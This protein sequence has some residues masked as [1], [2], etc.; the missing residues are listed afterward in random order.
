MLS[1]YATELFYSLYRRQNVMA[2]AELGVAY[3]PARPCSGAGY[4]NLDPQPYWVPKSATEPT[5]VCVECLV[6]EQNKPTL[7]KVTE[8]SSVP[9]R[10]PPACAK[11]ATYPDPPPVIL[12]PEFIA[13]QAAYQLRYE[14]TE[15]YSWVGSGP[16]W[17]R[18]L[19]W[20]Q[21]RNWSSRP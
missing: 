8:P 4:A 3:L 15:Y 14:N 5:R 2:G 17:S 9:Y 7:F 20:Y 11:R 1:S 16:K 21:D 12:L 6:G 13:A 19:G 10:T 18:S